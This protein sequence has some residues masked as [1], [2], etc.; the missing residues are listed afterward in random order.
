MRVN[1]NI[2]GSDIADFDRSKQ[3]KPYTGPVPTNNVYQ[4]KLKVFKYV[5]A[6]RDKLEQIR[7]GLELIPRKGRPEEKR[8]TG[9]FIMV[10][11]SLGDRNQ[12]TYVPFF[13]AIGITGADVDR[14]VITDEEGNVKKVGRWRN[15]GDMMLLARL[16]DEEDAE[17]NPR[18]G[19]D[20][21]A[22]LEDSEPESDDDDEDY[23]SDESYDDDDDYEEPTPPKRTRGKAQ[24]TRGRV[25]S[26]T[27]RTI[28]DDDE[29]PF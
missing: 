18:K 8:Y 9:F 23:D 29:E 11:R 24:S 15:T 6:T 7:I 21:W 5:S 28:S 10:F 22:A 26:R 13:D 4:F 2:R 3:Y 25:T 16:C 12:F 17:G 27:R 19:V 14:G 20:A 1:W